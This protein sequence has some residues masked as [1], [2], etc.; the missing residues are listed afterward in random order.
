M[1]HDEDDI[2]PKPGPGGRDFSFLSLSVADF[3]LPRNESWDYEEEKKFTDQPVVSAPEPEPK[4]TDTP[5]EVTRLPIQRNTY[6][7]PE[8]IDDIPPW[9]NPDPRGNTYLHVHE[10]H[11]AR[12]R[13]HH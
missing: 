11:P 7:Y 1:N 3:Q 6:D 12:I 10:Q 8:W 2:V 9:R 5:A 4:K 13:G